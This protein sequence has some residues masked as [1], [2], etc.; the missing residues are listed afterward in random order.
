MQIGLCAIINQTEANQRRIQGGPPFR[1]FVINWNTFIGLLLLQFSSAKSRLAARC[2]QIMIPVGLGPLQS[3]C[4]HILNRTPGWYYMA[5]N[6]RGSRLVLVVAANP[7]PLHFDLFCTLGNKH[8]GRY[9]A[10]R[11][12]L[13]GTTES[14]C[15]LET[16]WVPVNQ[17]IICERQM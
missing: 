17:A 6:L 12:V 3:W 8:S 1:S 13:I 14:R 4:N 16:N 7:L 9:T 15:T 5:C 2:V 10:S 11:D